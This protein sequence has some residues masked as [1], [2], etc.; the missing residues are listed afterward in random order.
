M[1]HP[2]SD[3]RVR[4]CN[5]G[6]REQILDV[7][8]A[9]REPE[10]EPHRLVN[11]LRWEPIAGVAD[12]AGHVLVLGYHCRSLRHPDARFQDF[13]EHHGAGRARIVGEQMRAVSGPS[14]SRNAPQAPS[15]PGASPRSRRRSWRSLQFHATSARDFVSIAFKRSFHD[16]TN[17]FAPAACRSAPSSARSRFRKRSARACWARR[18]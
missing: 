11:N 5:S 15:I 8:K 7:T 13:G 2:A 18:R 3:C 14:P 6:L 12:S 4:N 9:E 17:D 1:I 10:I 16:S